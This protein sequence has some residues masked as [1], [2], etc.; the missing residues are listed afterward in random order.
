MTLPITGRRY[1]IDYMSGLRYVFSSAYRSK[2]CNN[3]G[4]RTGMRVLY[5]IGGIIST[6][7][8][9]SAVLLLMLTIQGLLH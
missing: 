1:Q 7:V 4:Q 3:L 5:M 6:T 9:I 8:V 2:I